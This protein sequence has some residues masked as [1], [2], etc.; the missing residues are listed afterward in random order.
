MAPTP[1]WTST[2]RSSA[3]PTSP[4][5]SFIGYIEDLLYAEELDYLEALGGKIEVGLKSSKPHR[6]LQATLA[7]R[8]LHPAGLHRRGRTEPGSGAERGGEP[9]ARLLA[10]DPPRPCRPGARPGGSAF[11]VEAVK[12]ARDL[13]L[14]K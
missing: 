10:G 14:G 4:D 13:F 7:E 5:T 6:P 8:A 1:T 3:A 11:V 12:Q 2:N 9:H